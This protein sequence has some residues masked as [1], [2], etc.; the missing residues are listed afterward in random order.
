MG[1]SV[2]FVL[3]VVA[4]ASVTSQVTNI[5]GVGGWD[6]LCNRHQ[7]QVGVDVHEG[8]DAGVAE[9]RHSAVAADARD[10]RLDRHRRA[11]RI[12]DA[13]D[14]VQLVSHPNGLVEV[15][16]IARD[17]KRTLV[18]YHL[19]AN[20]GVHIGAMDHV[21]AEDGLRDVL[22]LGVGPLPTAGGK[23]AGLQQRP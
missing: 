9:R 16:S 11:P 10:G 1:S 2:F 12:V 4:A 23:V 13:A 18:G 22:V 21:A 20:V 8:E 3:Q 5:F 14:E 7:V 19:R 17:E 15:D 6:H